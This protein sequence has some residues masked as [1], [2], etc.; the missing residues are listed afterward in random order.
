MKTKTFLLL[1]MLLPVVTIFT[2]C[3]EKDVERSPLYNGLVT[4][5]YTEGDL[6]YFQLDDVRTLYPV[7][8]NTGK[9]WVDG[10]R[11]LINFYVVDEDDRGFTDAVYVNWIKPILTKATVESKGVE[12]DVVYGKDPVEIVRDWVTVVED[13]YLTLRF[14]TYWSGGVTH[15]VNLLTGVNPDNPY[16][17]EFRHN[18]YGDYDY[19]VGDGLV[20]FD[21]SKLPDTGGKIVKLKLKWISFS[22]PKSVEFDYC[23]SKSS[24]GLISVDDLRVV[25]DLIE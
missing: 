19:Y 11:A 23:T 8:M 7:N 22:G 6:L 17:V 10:Q 5:R 24:G 15:T 12:N 4:I 16:E 13:G 14:R 1:L 25:D 9:F 3:E 20:S 2:S 18:D 21:L